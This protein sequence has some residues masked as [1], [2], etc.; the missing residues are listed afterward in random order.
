MFHDHLNPYI[1]NDDA[2]ARM[3]ELESSITRHAAR[4]GRSRRQRRTWLA[5]WT[6]RPLIRLRPR[7]H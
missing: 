7:Q 3:G 2:R 5:R 1:A 6:M 4:R